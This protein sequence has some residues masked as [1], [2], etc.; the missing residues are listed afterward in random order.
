M[1]QD[2]KP[3]NRPFRDHGS[4]KALTDLTVQHLAR[5]PTLGRCRRYGKGGEIW[6]PEDK[7]DRLYLLQQGQVVILSQDAAGHEVIIRVIEA[8]EPFGE[9]CF[10]TEHSGTRENSAR[11]ITDSEALDLDFGRFL[12]HLQESQKALSSV[13]FT[14]CTRLAEAERRIEVL[15]YRAAEDRLARL[16]LQLATS[17]GKPSSKHQGEM[18]L[19]LSHEELAL[20]AAM[21]RPHVSVTMGKLRRLGLVHYGRGSLLRVNTSLLLSFVTKPKATRVR[22]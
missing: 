3:A 7:A 20:M 19:P 18:M 10:C 5:D 17:R 4:C 22:E 16:L 15:S 6:H 12:K 21:S 1:P 14:L 8:G 11:A 2:P 9:L 13:V